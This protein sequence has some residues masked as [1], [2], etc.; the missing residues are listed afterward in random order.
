MWG[1]DMAPH[2]PPTLG[3]PRQSRGAPISESL[4]GVDAVDHPR[5]HGCQ[6]TVHLAERLLELGELVQHGCERLCRRRLLAALILQLT[7][8][9]GEIAAQCLDLL[10]KA[11][12]LRLGARE[13]HPQA[14][15]IVEVARNQT[16]EQVLALFEPPIHTLPILQHLLTITHARSPLLSTAR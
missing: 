13:P 3:T 16:S 7:L 9:T 11:I 1:A 14:V 5:L 10:A 12:A 4:L 6:P 15:A 2:T 8:E